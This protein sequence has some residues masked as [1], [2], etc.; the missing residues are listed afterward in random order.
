MAVIINIDGK[1]K[2]I[3]NRRNEMTTT[4]ATTA[5]YREIVDRLTELGYT[6]AQIETITAWWNW[7]EHGD[8]LMTA[9]KAEID[10]AT[11]PAY[12]N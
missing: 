11:I 9:S 2:N 3:P 1:Q 12:N 5:T 4:T 10:L 8:W 6:A 7:R